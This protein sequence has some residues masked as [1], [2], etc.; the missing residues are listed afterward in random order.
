MFGANGPRREFGSTDVNRNGE[1]L[2][3][4]TRGQRET[5][6][7][8]ATK[9]CQGNT[10]WVAEFGVRVN[11]KYNEVL[12][13]TFLWSDLPVGEHTIRVGGMIFASKDNVPFTIKSG[14][15]TF[16]EL[17]GKQAPKVL[18]RDAALL[19]MADVHH[20]HKKPRPTP[21]AK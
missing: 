13:G 1:T 2:A 12:G 14:E 3:A 7:F 8:H 10:D 20:V 5:Y 18:N 4:N 17:Q 16:I 21:L 19:A 6:R 9:R 11:D 15:T